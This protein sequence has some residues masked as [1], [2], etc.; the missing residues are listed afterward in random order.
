MIHA[1]EFQH[2]IRA[3]IDGIDGAGKTWL[4]D[5]LVEP[6]RALGR[7]VIRAS[8]DGFHRPRSERYR[9]GEASPEGYYRDSFDNA[10]LTS[11]LLK[12]LGPNGDRRFRS[13]IFDYRSDG[14][15]SQCVRT[16]DRRAVL[17][18]DGVF[19][20]RPE[21]EQFWDFKVFVKTSF[22]SALERVMIRDA[23]MFGSRDAARDRYLTRYQPGQRLY[24]A[25]SMPEQSADA[26][27]INDDLAR[28]RL[29]C[30]RNDRPEAAEARS[31]AGAKA[32]S[33]TRRSRA[34]QRSSDLNEQPTTELD[35]RFGELQGEEAGA[36]EG[37]AEADWG[38]G[39]YAEV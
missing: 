20:L 16:A 35:A 7:P 9:R 8:I 27:I 3:A 22:A 15:V 11:A 4:A 21:L 24:L 25:E 26:V 1:L 38:V 17:L 32:A 23:S 5:E 18:F 29:T 19:L 12:P 33:S 37:E 36:A 2:P 13:A 31:S 39:G 14:S 34:R 28:P 10:A 30:R 6:L